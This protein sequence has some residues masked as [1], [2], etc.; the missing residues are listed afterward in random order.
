MLEVRVT[1]QACPLDS[2]AARV[3]ADAVWSHHSSPTALATARV[4]VWFAL[5]FRAGRRGVGGERSCAFFFVF[6]GWQVRTEADF[7][8]EMGRGA[9]ETRE[10]AR[11]RLGEGREG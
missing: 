1:S 3:R 6:G 2:A 5:D 4:G 7:E 10:E 9:K 11:E 8:L